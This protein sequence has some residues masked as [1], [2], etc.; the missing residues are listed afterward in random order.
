MRKLILFPALVIAGSI[1]AQDPCQ[2]NT[3]STP[4]IHT[5]KGTPIQGL[6]LQQIS[7][8]CYNDALNYLNTFYPNATIL[9]NP[10]SEYN[11]HSYAFHLSQGNTNKVWINETDTYSNPNLSKYWTDG[12]FVEV[13]D[14]SDGEKAYYYLGDHSALTTSTIS[15]QYESKWGKMHV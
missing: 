13:C 11:C 2:T 6:I 12:S 9:E 10:T 7:T 8:T 14:E 5:P 1:N 4:T 15:G 3:L